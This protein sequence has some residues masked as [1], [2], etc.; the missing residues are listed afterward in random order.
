MLP[1]PP[2]QW[3]ENYWLQILSLMG[4]EIAGLASDLQAQLEPL[5]A[6]FLLEHPD[7]WRDMHTQ[8]EAARRLGK[9]GQQLARLASGQVHL[10]PEEL[11]LHHAFRKS[12][13]H[14]GP[15]VIPRGIEWP[16]PE[17]D[18][19]IVA[20]PT[21]VHSFIETLLGWM[22]RDARE[23]VEVRLELRERLTQA[24]LSCRGT[25]P[26]LSS[27][28]KASEHNARRQLDWHLI[29]QM[30]RALQLQ[31]A[32]HEAMG[33]TTVQFDF[34][35]LQWPMPNSA[36]LTERPAVPERL[37]ATDGSIALTGTHW[38]VIAS[39]RDI[40]VEI[41]ESLRPMGLLVDFVGTVLEAEVFCKDAMPDGLISEAVLDGLRL[42]VLRQHLRARMGQLPE[43]EV[44]VDG[45]HCL[46]G[47]AARPTEPARIGG[48]ALR[49]ELPT[50]VQHEYG[51]NRPI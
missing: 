16:G 26:P 12:L 23:Q 50:L 9:V 34:P 17:N 30:A 43:I 8:I 49:Q 46:P 1:Q 4:E 29:E 7:R 24:R 33:V 48:Q 14:L 21:L 31:W 11:P 20:D 5:S 47:D 51:R 45:H 15:R 32:R 27:D 39:Q 2:A 41:R 3:P 19:H 40:R 37:D 44:A 22:T 18:A 13:D 42:Q 28:A 6:E 35:D 25:T 36:A 38:L 10:Q